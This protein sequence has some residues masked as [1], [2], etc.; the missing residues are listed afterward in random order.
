MN[1]LKKIL[2]VGGAGFIG[3]NLCRKLAKIPS[4]EVYSLDDYSSGNRRNHVQNVVY[5]TGES[6]QI[7]EKIKFKPQII[8]HLGEY[9]R[10][11]NSFFNFDKVFSSNIVGTSEVVKFAHSIN[12]KLIYAASSTK[13]SEGE[14]PTGQSPYAW[15]K[16]TNVE[17]IK[18]YSNWYG[19]NH[20]IAYF[21]NAYGNNEN[22]VGSYATLIGI[23]LEQ[24]RSGRPLTVVRPGTQKR[25]FTHVDDIVDALL[26]IEKY[27]SG[28][29]YG[30]GHEDAY[31]VLQVAEMFGSNIKYLDARKG[32]RRDAA[33]NI[34]KTIDLG[35]KSKRSLPEYINQQKSK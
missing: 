9:S 19:L 18:N 13:F 20:A 27:G 2:V 34:Q 14:M 21:Y 10:V 23:F 11:E 30:I 24:Y 32:N 33:L 8:Y 1:D 35:W 31:S 16:A 17:L 4:N 6:S 22:G 15:T 3:S 28:D 7:K 5:I 12:A 29:G 26:L 25:N